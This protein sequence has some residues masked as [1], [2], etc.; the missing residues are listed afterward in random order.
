MC[1]LCGL[2]LQLVGFFFPFF[3]FLLAGSTN[4]G[5]GKV[6]RRCGW[7]YPNAHPGKKHRQ[8]HQKRCRATASLLEDDAGNVAAGVVD[9]SVGPR[10]LLAEENRGGKCGE[11][12]VFIF[13]GPFAFFRVLIG[14]KLLCRRG[15][16]EDISARGGRRKRCERHESI[17]WRR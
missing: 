16:D 2:S 5:G 10:D 13:F 12:T 1:F 7:V 4:R 11:F 8:A 17:R 15:D 6:C 14:M 3:F 9:V